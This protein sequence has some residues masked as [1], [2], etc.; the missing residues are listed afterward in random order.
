[1][2]DLLV[3]VFTPT[4]AKV[5]VFI[6]PKIEMVST[7]H[8]SITGTFVDAEGTTPDKIQ[9]NP[10]VLPYTADISSATQC[11]HRRIVKVYV[12]RGRQPVNMIGECR[13]D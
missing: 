9:F 8:Y 2:P 13:K 1:M 6:N 10:E 4:G 7:H 11:A 5:G 3:E 12:Q